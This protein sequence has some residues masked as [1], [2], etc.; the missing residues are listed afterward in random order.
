MKQVRRGLTLSTLNVFI[1]HYFSLSW[2]RQYIVDK[3]VYKFI[4][5]NSEE[6]EEYTLDEDTTEEKYALLNNRT[7]MYFDLMFLVRTAHERYPTAELLGEIMKHFDALEGHNT[8]RKNIQRFDSPLNSIY[9]SIAISNKLSALNEDL[10]TLWKQVAN[11]PLD[12]QREND[13]Y[14]DAK[15]AE[16][17]ALGYSIEGEFTEWGLHDDIQ[18]GITEG[19]LK[20][21]I[22]LRTALEKRLS[23]K[24]LVKYYESLLLEARN[25]GNVNLV[26]NW[27]YLIQGEEEDGGLDDYLVLAWCYRRISPNRLDPILSPVNVLWQKTI[28]LI[29]FELYKY[30]EYHIRS[31]FQSQEGQLAFEFEKSLTEI[32][33]AQK[34]L[35]QSMIQNDN[36]FMHGLKELVFDIPRFF[37]A[38][39]LELLSTVSSVASNDYNAEFIKQLDKTFH[40]IQKSW[41]AF[42]SDWK[43]KLTSLINAVRIRDELLLYY[44]DC[45]DLIKLVEGAFASYYNT[46][47][48]QFTKQKQSIQH[49]SDYFWEQC[50][51]CLPLC[52]LELFPFRDEL[53]YHSKKAREMTDITS[54]SSSTPSVH[55][56]AIIVIAQLQLFIADCQHDFERTDNSSGNNAKEEDDY[57]KRKYILDLDGELLDKI[58]VSLK[59]LQNA[60]YSPLKKEFILEYLKACFE[61]YKVE[62][63]YRKANYSYARAESRLMRLQA[64]FLKVQ[65]YLV[66]HPVEDERI[67]VVEIKKLRNVLELLRKLPHVG[68]EYF[69]D[70]MIWII[71]ELLAGK[72]VNLL[73]LELF[74]EQKNYP[75]DLFFAYF[76]LLKYYLPANYS[77]QI[78]AALK[79]AR[80]METEDANL[81][82][83]TDPESEAITQMNYQLQGNLRKL[84]E[85]TFRGDVFIP[86]KEK[87][88]PKDFLQFKY[89]LPI[90]AAFQKKLLGLL[91]EWK[92]WISYLGNRDRNV[93]NLFQK[94]LQ[95]SFQIE[96]NFLASINDDHYYTQLNVWMVCDSFL[97]GRRAK[98]SSDEP[99]LISTVC[100]FVI[101]SMNLL[102]EENA[103]EVMRNCLPVVSLY[104][105]YV[106]IVLEN[107]KSK[108]AEIE[109]LENKMIKLTDDI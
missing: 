67:Q 66:T 62:M 47:T 30:D 90:M 23:R 59:L 54:L 6:D 52:Y 108:V 50:D 89:L 60:D 18:G 38:H 78:D 26:E 61:L 36:Q 106:E 53:L 5:Y 109:E 15:Y 93:L 94:K 57:R 100:E 105:E 7:Q 2:L 44:K 88:P 25:E 40:V 82:N 77:A 74:Q 84:S 8:R 76:S 13:Y 103:E 41:K 34:R 1:L 32:G 29:E 28:A 107:P 9:F 80:V 43:T 64:T 19:W 71:N 95:E 68:R 55:S 56:Q 39:L 48:K 14:L 85:S 12:R 42:E 35:I 45:P 79:A 33:K 46:I 81:N 99:K 102:D 63:S 22:K 75:N 96:N 86:E 65:E 91:L 83:C 11:I 4:H 27:E 97:E 49:H 101:K 104:L 21:D 17:K 58:N 10:A 31:P 87:V 3:K 37:R 98:R 16:L 20:T 51:K 70:L 72:E 24:D 73:L 69:K 92:S